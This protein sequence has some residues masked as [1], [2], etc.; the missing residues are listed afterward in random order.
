V[1]GITQFL[2]RDDEP[3]TQYRKGSRAYW[4][5]Y[6]TGI[7]FADGG[8]KPS[9]DAYRLP[10]VGPDAT[11]TGGTATLW[12]MVRPGARASQPIVHIQFAPEG[13]T[14]FSDVSDP[15]TV[16][17]PKGFFQVEVK[18]TQS[19]M[20]R[21]TWQPPASAPKQSLIDRLLGKKLAPPPL[22]NSNPAAVRVTK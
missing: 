6:Q 12:G 9:Y 17:D 10:F 4:R 5:T 14:T 1:A 13:S 18:P 8:P 22:Y 15:V 16:T 19:G 20:W 7:E 21:F 11:P 3:W 2:L